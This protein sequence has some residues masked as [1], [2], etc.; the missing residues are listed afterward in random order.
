MRKLH[1]STTNC[2][3]FLKM[4]LRPSPTQFWPQPSHM[5]RSHPGAARALIR[6]HIGKP[7]PKLTKRW[8]QKGDEKGACMHATIWTLVSPLLRRMSI[9]GW[10]SRQLEQVGNLGNLVKLLPPTLW[11][12][13]FS[14]RVIFVASCTV[15]QNSASP[16]CDA[17][18]LCAEFLVLGVWCSM[19]SKLMVVWL[20]S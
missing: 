15:H 20:P 9:Y 7:T 1:L 12:L 14:A 13:E 4:Y 8:R 19:H 10:A 17:E 11:R 16:H 6:P 3:S 18:M 5:Q 2:V